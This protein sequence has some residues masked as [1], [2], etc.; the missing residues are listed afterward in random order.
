MVES[1][2]RAVKDRKSN[3]GSYIWILFRVITPGLSWSCKVFIN[4]A[5][6]RWKQIF[7]RHFLD[8]TTQKNQK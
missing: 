8:L 4:L 1:N 6:Y 7:I 3:T 5:M 2:G